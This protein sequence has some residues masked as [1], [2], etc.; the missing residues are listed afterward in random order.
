M[1]A[2]FCG[3][4]EQNVAIKGSCLEVYICKTNFLSC[5]CLRLFQKP[6]LKALI[7]WGNGAGWAVHTAACLC[8]NCR[9]EDV[10][11][12][13]ENMIIK[14]LKWV[15]LY[16]QAQDWPCWTYYGPWIQKIVQETQFQFSFPEGFVD[17]KPINSYLLF[18][19]PLCN[20]LP[21]IENLVF[22]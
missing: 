4:K 8:L 20:L 22:P 21:F 16:K 9:Q 5:F 1:V 13:H 6:N 2:N 7:C 18:T 3:F 10:S 15:T 11:V 19:P 12:K 14:T 17:L